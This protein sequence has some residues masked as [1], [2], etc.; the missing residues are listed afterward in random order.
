MPHQ[1]AFLNQIKSGDFKLKKAT[2]VIETAMV[3]QGTRETVLSRMSRLLDLTRQVPRL[4]DILETR[5]KLRK[6]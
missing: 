3:V 5:S 2:K 4:Q 6:V 1:Q